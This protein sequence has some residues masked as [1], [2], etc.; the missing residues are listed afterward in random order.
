[1]ANEFVSIV[2]PSARPDRVTATVR[3]LQVQS[4]PRSMYEII[5][6]TPDPCELS[7]HLGAEVRFVSS[8]QLF[9]PGKMRNLGAEH[10]LGNFLC[11]FDD[12][13]LAP[14]TFLE[15]MTHILQAQASVGA[16]GCR[17][18]AHDNTFWDRC[19]DQALFTAY[20]GRKAGMV[21]GLGSAAMVVR[22]EAFR[23]AGGFDE[24]L[25]A[26]E[27]WDLSLKLREHGWKCHFTIA[28]EVRHDHRR[29]GFFSILHSAWNS[30][31]DSGLIVQKR[32]PISTS[33]VARYMVLADKIHLYWLAILPYASLMTIA[34]LINSPVSMFPCLPVV[35]LSR[36][37]YQLGVFKSLR[38]G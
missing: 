11:F 12:D 36:L 13:C 7:C 4:I 16:V 38:N 9:P 24:V 19:A 23:A 28:T 30:G 25:K 5:V 27:D 37:A 17:V 34:W 3:S 14:D 21:S 26:S 20:Q 35:F 32:H 10:A 33:R 8:G 2:I 29:G 1:M 18:V 31:R 15:H 6:V 22:S